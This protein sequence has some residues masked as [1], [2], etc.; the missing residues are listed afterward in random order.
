MK[1][2]PSRD[3]LIDASPVWLKT[4]Y[5]SLMRAVRAIMAKSGGVA[6]LDAKAKLSRPYHYLRSLLAIHDVPDMVGLDVPWWTY[7]AI[8]Y[9]NEWMQNRPQLEVFEWGSGASTLW[10]AKR[11]KRVISV[12]HDPKWH[13]LLMPF[14]SLHS[15]VECILREPDPLLVDEKYHSSKMPNMNFKSYVFAIQEFPLQ[16]DLIVIDGRARTACLAACEPYLKNDGL[17]VFDNANRARYQNA[18][19]Q[20]HYQIKRFV[21]RVPGSPLSGETAILSKN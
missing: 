17:I 15:N 20:S 10:L 9:L 4:G 14:L 3:N 19:L 6:Y 2:R 18:L 13:N 1:K 7:S 8:D 21:G 16:Y 11:A 12:E 5:V